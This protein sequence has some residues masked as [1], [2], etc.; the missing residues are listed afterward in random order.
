MSWKPLN[1]FRDA[2]VPKLDNLR[3]AE[4]AGIRGPLT[5]WIH[6]REVTQA[7]SLPKSL[8]EE[9]FILRSGSPTED[10]HHTSNAGQLLSLVVREPSLFERSLADVI[11]A[12]PKAAE[13]APLGA[14]FAQPL[15]SAEEA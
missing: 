10:T 5:Y 14:V 11:A 8:V 6:A 7:G 2:S 4:A 15:V 1:Q 13:G 12:L 9:P 3:R